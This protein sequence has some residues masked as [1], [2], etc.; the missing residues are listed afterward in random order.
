MKQP[1]SFIFLLSLLA[2]IGSGFLDCR[3]KL[4]ETPPRIAGQ[5]PTFRQNSH[6]RWE[7][8]NGPTRC[9]I[10]A[11]GSIGED[12]F[13][14]SSEDG[15]FR[16]RDEGQSWQAVD[17]GLPDKCE[18]RAFATTDNAL[19]VA[20]YQ[21]QVYRS[22][23][24]GEKWTKADSGIV[25][26]GWMG[27]LQ[28]HLQTFGKRL[29]Y[30]YNDDAVYC[31]SD[32]GRSWSEV[33]D[34]LPAG[35]IGLMGFAVID[36]FLFAG[37]S[38]GKVFRLTKNSPQW[39]EMAPT[40]PG[41][42]SIAAIGKDLYTISAPAN[43]IRKSSDLGQTWTALPAD[44][45]IHT[46]V[47]DIIKKRQ[48]LFIATNQG[49]FRYGDGSGLQ[50]CHTRWKETQCLLSRDDFSLAG[51]ANGIWISRN[52]G[53]FW[54]SAN[55]GLPADVGVNQVFF[56]G[57]SLFVMTFAGL[58]V[59]ADTGANWELSDDSSHFAITASVK[60]KERYIGAN[61][62]HGLHNVSPEGKI[63]AGSLLYGPVYALVVDNGMILAGG[64]GV[65]RSNDSMLN[66]SIWENISMGLPE[67]TAVKAL[68]S[69]GA[70]FAG[71]DSGVYIREHQRWRP[72]NIGLKCKTV[73]HL[74]LCG[75]T[76]IAVCHDSIKVSDGEGDF[77][78]KVRSHIYHYSGD[79][80]TWIV[81]TSRLFD[82]LT[83]TSFAAQGECLFV[84][85]ENGAY[86]ST[87]FGD[88]WTPM[89]NGLPEDKNIQALA[90]GGGYLFAGTSTG[91]YRIVLA[92]STNQ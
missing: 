55:Y 54:T 25:L 28:H 14:A 40:E 38:H 35:R 9:R 8:A 44:F 71:T 45:P 3:P 27:T 29:F 15:I 59:S 30:F 18:G 12:L 89:I 87:D 51:T 83:V 80:D 65:Y 37:C 6:T 32:M 16:S 86:S 76:L 62:I 66:L 73:D 46:N 60:L 21:G 91:L 26:R 53:E 74:A 48:A 1:A 52:N 33:D 58:F 11:F 67:T 22:D 31:S 42:L 81:G 49:L 70:L 13:A 5:P 63:D 24:H 75:S 4:K 78:S 84:G 50:E 10:I 47:F 61:G 43:F 17:S 7:R 57:E 68:V 39:E 2:L 41:I 90:A 77:W 72:F 69:R 20:T 34:G 79:S 85:S 36:S 82:S 92:H 19:F 88:S 64:D 23:D 56:I